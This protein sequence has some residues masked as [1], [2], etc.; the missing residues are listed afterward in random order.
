[1][2]DDGLAINNMKTIDLTPGGT[3]AQ[4]RAGCPES[5]VEVRAQT[6]VVLDAAGTKV[7]T[8]R[9]T[10]FFVTSDGKLA[11]TYYSVANATMVQVR[12]ADGNIMQARVDRADPS[13]DI[14]ILKVQRKRPGQTFQPMALAES[15][16]H[17][18]ARDRLQGLVT[19]ENC[20]ELTEQT[21]EFLGKRLAGANFELNFCD[22]RRAVL[23]IG[24]SAQPGSAGGPVTDRRGKVVG[25]LESAV[26]HNTVQA[27]P[28]EYLHRLLRS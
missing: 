21:G 22:P 13:R 25:L 23:E 11:T 24:M 14:A 2:S 8:E 3:R 9:S 6:I 10:G 12:T 15:S 27:V 28:V 16:D 26:M 17:L 4:E 5:V 18:N 7:I 20:A 1:M 19:S